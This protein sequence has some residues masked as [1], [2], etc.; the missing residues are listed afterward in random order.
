MACRFARDIF[1][2]SFH[3]EMALFERERRLHVYIQTVRVTDAWSIF[4]AFLL[5][6][7]TPSILKSQK[8]YPHQNLH[9]G[10]YNAYLQCT[11][12][13]ICRSQCI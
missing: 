2:S 9:G 7:V 11:L 12:T 4:H 1:L 5:Q 13:Y 6:N 3:R 8:K 10:I